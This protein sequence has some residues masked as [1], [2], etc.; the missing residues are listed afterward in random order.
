MTVPR[1]TLRSVELRSVSGPPK[2][3]I[4]FE[5]SGRIRI[6]TAPFGPEPKT[7]RPSSRRVLIARR[8]VQDG[9]LKSTYIY[10]VA[11]VNLWVHTSL[12]FL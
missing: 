3:P 6:D 5:P 8:S 9:L 11:W 1:L 2:G 4:V 12:R 10:D 7:P